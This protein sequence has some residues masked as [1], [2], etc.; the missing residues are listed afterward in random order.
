MASHSSSSSTMMMMV[1][2]W[3]IYGAITLESRE[4]YAS[5]ALTTAEKKFETS[6]SWAAA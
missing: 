3:I 2:S 6:V 1:M 5:G 4:Y